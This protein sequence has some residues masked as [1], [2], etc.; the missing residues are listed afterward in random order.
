MS[1]TSWGRLD[2]VNRGTQENHITLGLEVSAEP[3][4]ISFTVVV[5]LEETGA[6]EAER[7]E[8]RAVNHGVRGNGKDRRG[9]RGQRAEK[10]SKSYA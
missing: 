6:A 7:V 3:T 8:T 10:N 2:H 9:S 4:V 5:E 1:R